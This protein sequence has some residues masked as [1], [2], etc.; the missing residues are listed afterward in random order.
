MEGLLPSWLVLCLLVLF[1]CGCVTASKQV[2]CPVAGPRSCW[3]G[4]PY[5]EVNQEGCEQCTCTNNVS[6]EYGRGTPGGPPDRKP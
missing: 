4:L 6:Y 1:A 2:R 3:Q 5:C